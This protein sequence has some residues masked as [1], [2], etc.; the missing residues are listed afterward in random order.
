MV[1]AEVGPTGVEHV[2]DPKG[3][4]IF[5]IPRKKKK[6]TADEFEKFP[7]QGL[8]L[9]VSMAHTFCN[10]Y[11]CELLDVFYILTCMYISKS[12]N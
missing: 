1:E 6:D 2:E 12:V 8:K 7:L 10:Y 5:Q 3:T 9:K 11:T 4:G